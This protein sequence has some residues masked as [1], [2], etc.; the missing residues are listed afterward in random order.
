MFQ[1]DYIMREIGQLTRMMGMLLLGRQVEAEDFIGEQ[2]L[3]SD[4]AL[5]L[6]T[7]L[8]MVAKGD[9]NG[10][11]NLLFEYIDEEPRQAL[12]DVAIR[13]YSNLN[14]LTDER[15]EACDYSREEI[16]EGLR[17]VEKRFVDMGGPA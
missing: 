15:L 5:I 3:L 4:D 16:A 11:E 2:G 14:R 13:F 6:Q 9:I 8:N 12:L 17:A 10:A 1:N 7:L